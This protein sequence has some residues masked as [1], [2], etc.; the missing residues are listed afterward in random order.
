MKTDK[1]LLRA[2][3]Y[4]E[5]L[6]DNYDTYSYH[7]LLFK[8]NLCVE[9]KNLKHLEINTKY[10]T[11]QDAKRCVYLMTKRNKLPSNMDYRIWNSNSDWL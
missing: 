2:G 7:I 10:S 9:D 6:G 4:T 3:R 8:D 1:E 5:V 11:K